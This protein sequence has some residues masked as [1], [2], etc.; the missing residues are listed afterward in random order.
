VVTNERAVSAREWLVGARTI[1][2]VTDDEGRHPTARN[3]AVE[4]ARSSGA[5]VLLYDLEAASPLAS[6]RPTEWSSEGEPE[7]YPDPLGVP[8][9]ERLGHSQLAQQVADAAADGVEAA[10]WLPDR[11]GM[12]A[13]LDYAR[14]HRADV[15]LI[16]DELVG[17]DLLDRLL[18]KSVADA[19]EAE[20]AASVPVLLVAADGSVR[21]AMEKETPD[22]R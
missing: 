20:R 3:L 5:R 9:L 11:L 2:A 19:A 7:L 13:L 17:D 4:S 14:R 18:G 6:P 15:V 22:D 8:E 12:N 1:V 21:D 16:P 10:A